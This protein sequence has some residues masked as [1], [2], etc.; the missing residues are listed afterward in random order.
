MGWWGPCAVAA[1]PSWLLSCAGLA[2]F[3][4]KELLSSILLL[5]S[6][7]WSGTA[8]R[9]GTAGQVSPSFG[10]LIGGGGC[11]RSVQGGPVWAEQPECSS[12][13]PLL[14]SHPG[15]RD[16]GAGH[17]R[18]GGAAPPRRAEADAGVRDRRG[19]AGHGEDGVR[20]GSTPVKGRVMATGCPPNR[21][22]PAQGWAGGRGLCALWRRAGSP[23]LGLHS[24]P[25]LFHSRTPVQPSTS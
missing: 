10:L 20:T 11:C 9:G 21:A 7:S 25:F 23:G 5:C 15:C 4:G 18:Q 3:W 1:C 19:G 8:G 24:L 22:L 2:G 12:C 14:R 16:P 6:S 17:R 13:P